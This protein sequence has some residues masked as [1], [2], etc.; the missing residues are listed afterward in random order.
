MIDDGFELGCLAAL[1][2]EQ[3]CIPSRSHPEVAVDRF[4]KMK[5]G[6]RRAG[7]SEGRGDLAGDMARF[8]EAADDELALAVED[9]ANGALELAAQ[10]VGQ[11]IKGA[12]LV[13]ENLSLS[14]MARPLAHPAAGCEA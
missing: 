10:A 14:A 12:R 4:R 8:A 13:M 1:R 5:E 3:R 11:G 9:Q 2:D 7:R 6:R